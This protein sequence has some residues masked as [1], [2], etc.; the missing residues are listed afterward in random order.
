MYRKLSFLLF[1]LMVCSP[2]VCFPQS[3]ID[4]LQKILERQSQEQIRIDQRQH[5]EN[6]ATIRARSRSEILSE[7]IAFQRYENKLKH[8]AEVNS[9]LNKFN[10]DLSNFVITQLDEIS[11][12]TSSN[13]SKEYFDKSTSFLEDVIDF[14]LKIGTYLN[15]GRIH[16]ALIDHKYQIEYYETSNTVSIESDFNNY[17]SNFF[18][19]H[20]STGSDIPPEMLN[21]YY[22]GIKSTLLSSENYSKAKDRE[23]LREQAILLREQSELMQQLEEVMRKELNLLENESELKK[24]NPER[25]KMMELLIRLEKLELEQKIREIDL[26]LSSISNK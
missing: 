16:A 5:D 22:Y 20:V 17:S 25:Y 8:F 15:R 12:S 19:E 14:S 9:S 2:L 6:M 10:L 23:N 1:L 4:L 24:N 18:N 7:N 11:Q 13:I 21:Y 26:K 3:G